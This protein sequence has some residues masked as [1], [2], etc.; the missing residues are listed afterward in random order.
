VTEITILEPVTQLRVIE[1]DVMLE[2]FEQRTILQIET[3]GSRDALFL[4][5]YPIADTAPTIGTVMVFDGDQWVPVILEGGGAV[6][7][8]VEDETPTGAINGVNATFTTAFSYAAGS[9]RVYL[10]GLRQ[11]LGGGDDFTETGAS[12]FAFTVPPASGDT[13]RVD[14]ARA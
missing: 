4:R 8:P 14:Y 13:I 9:L 2:V 3:G 1:S 12:T 6:I 11:R 10:N 7:P 5:G